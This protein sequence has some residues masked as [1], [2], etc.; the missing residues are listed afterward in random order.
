[1][2]KKELNIKQDESNLI[3]FC[4]MEEN[5]KDDFKLNDQNL[6]AEYFLVESASQ[7]TEATQF[8]NYGHISGI[9]N[10]TSGGSNSQYLNGGYAGMIGVA[11]S[12]KVFP[13]DQ[14]QIE[15]YGSYNT[16]TANTSSL[17]GF[18]SALISAFGLTTPAPGET[19]TAASALNTWGGIEAGG[20][21][22]GTNDNTDPKAFVNIVLFDKN[23][24]FL[25]V[26]Y[27]QLKGT[28]LYYMTA[29]Y[30]V[31]EAGYAYLYVSNE[32]TSMTDVYFDDVRI[33]YTPSAII[34]GNEYYPFGLQTAN[35]WTRDGSS[36]N[37]LANGSTEFNPTS[38]VYDLDFRNYDPVLGRL[39]QVDPL[40]TNDVS[41]SP[42]H[43]SFNNPV[44][45]ID[46]SGAWGDHGEVANPNPTY[47][48]DQS[49]YGIGAYKKGNDPGGYGSSMTL[50]FT[51]IYSVTTGIK[52]ENG[53]WIPEY[54]THS[55]EFEREYLEIRDFGGMEAEEVTQR[56]ARVYVETDGVGHAYIEVNGTV[57]SYGRYDGS[58]SPSSGRFGP[59]GPGVLMKG[60][61]EYALERMKKYST[62]VYNFPEADANAIYD[63][64][65]TAYNSGEQSK[66]GGMVINSYLLIGG[67]CTTTTCGALQVGGVDIPTIQT[68]VGF[69]QYMSKPDPSMSN[70]Y[71]N[72]SG[73]H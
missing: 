11:K 69:V 55:Y 46:P 68:P 54:T 28:S 34:Q 52:D 51:T 25:D 45:F 72:S 14:L 56:G 10:H 19:G 3:L 36:N 37:Y 39:N 44:R 43:Y 16:P 12:Y 2:L 31:K 38:S 66:H 18:A 67:N 17:T 71:L 15:A 13:G 57:F 9:N 62:Y 65:N 63:Y 61:H 49:S 64:L 23:F 58:Y 53:K 59:V 42:Y 29:S 21:G 30:T 35:S 40:A 22:D 50:V 5:T 8:N 27:A 47:L 20:W 70:Y 48:H 4:F 1:L 7:T 73:L 33:S 32:Q 41:L 26:A 6:D 24:K 60:T